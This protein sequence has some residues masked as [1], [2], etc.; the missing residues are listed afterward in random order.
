M[1]V[2]EMRE[3]RR[4]IL[5]GVCSLCVCVYLGAVIGRSAARVAETEVE[6]EPSW[7]DRAP[8]SVDYGEETEQSLETETRPSPRFAYLVEAGATTTPPPELVEKTGLEDV[9]IS[10]KTSGQFHES[11]LK[12]LLDTWV[13]HVQ[14]QTWFFTDVDDAEL[15]QKTDGHVINTN[16]SSSHRRDALCC[17]MAVEYD[18]FMDSGKKWFC[19][20]DDDNYVNTARL[21]EL[22]SGYSPQE[23]W[24]LGKNSIRT[25]LQIMDRAH[26]GDRVSFWFGTGGAGFCISRALALKMSP[27]ASGGRFMRVGDKIRLPDDVTMGYIIEHLLKTRL[28]VID[29][30]HSHLEQMKFIRPTELDKQ[31]SFSYSQYAD[32]MNVVDLDILSEEKD[33]TRFYSLHCLLHPKKAFCPR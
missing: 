27:F 15:H 14:Q 5:Q 33:P 7:Q 22:L 8:M 31:I 13:P 6:R 21:A 12:P 30:F 9:F 28:T 32:E 20:F 4:R 17:K 1:P 19:H 29:E 26:N 16:C 11:R 3:T 2:A 10:V 25:P 23:D 24:Y 18:T